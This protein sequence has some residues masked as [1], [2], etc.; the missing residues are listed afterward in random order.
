MHIELKT[1]EQPIYHATLIISFHFSLF[2]LFLA[3]CYF[4]VFVSKDHACMNS[5]V[6]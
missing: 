1:H 6:D 5:Y 4:F 2:I 3:P